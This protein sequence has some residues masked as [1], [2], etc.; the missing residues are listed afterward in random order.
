MPHH[1]RRDQFLSTPIERFKPQAG[2]SIPEFL[3]RL[4]KTGAQ[5]RKIGEAYS[6]WKE[7]L[8]QKRTIYAAIAGAP[9][10]FGFGPTIT[11]MIEQRYIDVLAIPGSQLGHDIVETLGGKH[12]QGTPNVS[13][14]EL[15]QNEI[16]RYWDTFGDERDFKL[17]D[18][19]Y[20]ELVASLDGQAITTRAFLHRLGLALIPHAKKEGILTTAARNNFPIF[21]VGIADSVVGTDIAEVTYKYDK[22]VFFDL[23]QDNLEATMIAALT[24]DLGARTSIVI[25]GGGWTRN[26]SQQAQ[27]CMYMIGR[28]NIAK[29]HAEAIRFSYDPAETGGLSGSTISEGI[30]WRKYDRNVKPAESNIDANF[31]LAL[32]VTALEEEKPQRP[33]K[34]NFVLDQKDKIVVATDQGTY[35]L[36]E[37]FRG[38]NFRPI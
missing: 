23:A 30:S 33:W 16:N 27:A 31:A 37:Y 2:T 22:T 7:M 21:C 11:T 35:W 17:S 3:T 10:P 8:T 5:P 9:V 6:L 14:P 32:L 29:G 28:E 26:W 36:D 25:F 13:D 1:E 19:I 12:F 15:I 34:L 24:E 18:D 38:K 20:K 4:E